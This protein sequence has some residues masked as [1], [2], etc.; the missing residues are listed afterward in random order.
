MS[1][2]I[3]LFQ[4]I[5]NYTSLKTTLKLVQI[6]KDTIDNF[7]IY[8]LCD[9]RYTKKLNN[10]ILKQPIFDS[11][12]ILNACGN[13]KINNVNHMKKL[14]ILYCSKNCGINQE[15]INELTNL[16][17]LEASDNS[18]INNVNHMKKLKI[19]NCSNNCGINQDGINKL[20]TLEYLDA[21]NNSKINNVNHMKKLKVLFCSKNCGIN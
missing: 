18:K 14:K 8:N 16:E 6:N 2:F 5:S 1:L 7:R 21:N 11:L 17:Y 3:D 15:G 12:E 4:F 19:L 20:T 13:S 10:D 9:D